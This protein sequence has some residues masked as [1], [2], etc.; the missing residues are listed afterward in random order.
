MDGGELRFEREDQI[1][2]L[3]DGRLLGYA[4]YGDP[5]GYPVFAFHGTPGC[6]H[7]FRLADPLAREQGFRLIAP[8]RPGFSLS[9][10][11][12]SRSLSNWPKDVET[13]ADD[14]EIDRFAVIGVSGGGPYAAATAALLVARVSGAAL[15]S[16]AGPVGIPGL[17]PL[18]SSEHRRIFLHLARSPH[19]ANA[20]F[21]TM[22]IA[23]TYTP[24]LALRGLMSRAADIDRNI[25][26]RPEI[27]SNLIESMAEGL[28]D[29][30]SG[31]AQDLR[32]FVAPWDFQ[33]A[34][35]SAPC[36]V[37]Q[38]DVDRNVP[39]AAARYLADQIPDCVFEPLPETGHYWVYEHFDKV[40]AWIAD[41]VRVQSDVE[42][43]N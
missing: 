24:T 35:I 36:K 1:L 5:N 6:R 28:I 7:M 14:L 29:G 43:P 15:V 42:D 10:P 2:R 22:R 41:T 23:V 8:D 13:L 32:L 19:L 26:L 39:P 30:I 21:T 9:S 11:M 40:L 37:W 12:P 31:A 16:P 25:L 38:G 20:V 17:V 18:L 3:A 34:R 27:G 33:F 4:E